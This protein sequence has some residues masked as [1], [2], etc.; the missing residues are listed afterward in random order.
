MTSLA[1][2]PAPK[3]PI[4]PIGLPPGV[5]HVLL[6]GGTFDPVH[7]GHTE[8]A[9][10]A[11]DQ[12]MGREAWTVYVPAARSPFKKAGPI[13]G[14]ADR[15][16]M[17]RIAIRAVPR[18]VIWPDELTR[19]PP[20]YWI[21]TLHRARAVI[22][23]GAQLRF[24]IGADQAVGFRGWHR[25]RE[26]LLAAEPVVMARPPLRTAAELGQALKREGWSESE[27]NGWTAR[28]ADAAVLDVSAT[29]TRSAI[30]TGDPRVEQWLDPGVMSLIRARG[31]YRVDQ[32]AI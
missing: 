16:A 24:L 5:R 14:D 1:G 23:P 6:F 25:W 27:V 29:D 30:A 4:A 13:A 15:L 22:D 20:S 2:S 18:A 17:L 32:R 31:L 19:P 3:P 8:A 11:R 9:A 28:F 26:I 12:V 7:R 21:D 10:A